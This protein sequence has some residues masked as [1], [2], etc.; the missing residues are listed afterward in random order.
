[1]DAKR[2]HGHRVGDDLAVGVKKGARSAPDFGGGKRQNGESRE[3][4]YEGS[5]T[6]DN[7]FVRRL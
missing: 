6:F 7:E 1:M 2:I 5:H 3:R 4:L